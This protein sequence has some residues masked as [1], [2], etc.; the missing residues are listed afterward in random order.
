V[1]DANNELMHRISSIDILFIS[2]IIN[3]N[4]YLEL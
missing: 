1:R 4:N 3:E 2:S